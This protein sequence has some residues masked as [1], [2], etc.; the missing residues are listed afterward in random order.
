MLIA[1][2]EDMAAGAVSFRYRNGV[3]NNGVP[4]ADA[5]DE[6][7]AV[8]EQRLTEPDALNTAAEV[9]A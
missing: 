1:G 5:I 3:Q 6:I 2:A 9:T 8:V 7:V 4:I